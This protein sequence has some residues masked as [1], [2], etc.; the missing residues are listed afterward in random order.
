MANE[1]KHDLLGT[2]V[3]LQE[4]RNDN[5]GTIRGVFLRSNPN[6]SECVWVIVQMDSGSFREVRITQLKPVTCFFWVKIEFDQNRK[7]AAIKCVREITSMDLRAA[8]DTVEGD[9]CVKRNVNL[10]EAED[11]KRQIEAAGFTACILP[12]E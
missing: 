9:C 10:K 3:N 2:K 11:I 8:K 12:M 6:I 5:F 4:N 7:I 1:F